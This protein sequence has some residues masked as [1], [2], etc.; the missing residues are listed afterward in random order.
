MRHGF[1]RESSRWWTTVSWR[2]PACNFEQAHS[3]Y[4]ADP[5]RFPGGSITFDCGLV[6]RNIPHEWE[7]AKEMYI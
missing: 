3:T 5:A 2:A 7:T 4:F 6:M 1:A